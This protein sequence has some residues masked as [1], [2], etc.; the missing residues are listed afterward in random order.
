MDVFLSAPGDGH[1]IGMTLP[2]HPVIERQWRDGTLTRVNEDG[3]P[4]GEGDE[5]A[6]LSDGDPADNPVDPAA[7]VAEPVRPAANAP[8]KDWAEFAV[9]LGVCGD[10]EAK[11]MTKADLVKACTPPEM[12]PAEPGE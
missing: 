6:V 2:L 5:H 4:F 10:G 7:P 3:S 8:K 12:Q 9:A 11:A 1:V